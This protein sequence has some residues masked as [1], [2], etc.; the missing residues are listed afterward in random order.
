[1][2]RR[3][4]RRTRKS[5][6]ETKREKKTEKAQEKNKANKKILFSKKL[7][8]PLLILILVLILVLSM[9]PVGEFSAQNKV[10]L[11]SAQLVKSAPLKEIKESK[12]FTKDSIRITDST[13]DRQLKNFMSTK[14]GIASQDTKL[15]K[16]I[17]SASSKKFVY[18]SQYYNGI[19]VYG[20]LNTFYIAN[21]K[22]FFTK[23][24][25]HNIENLDTAPSVSIESAKSKTKQQLQT[26]G[27]ER[28]RD[29][30]SEQMIAPSVQNK[31]KYYDIAG[32][33]R[34]YKIFKNMNELNSIQPKSVQLI[35]YPFK[36][37]Y[38]LAY[39]IVYPVLYQ[40]PAQ[41]IYFVNAHTGEIIDSKDGLV[42]YDLGG[43][44]AVKEWEDPFTDHIQLDQPAQYNK[45]TINNNGI[46]I[47]GN[48]QFTGYYQ[49]TGLNGSGT[50]YSYLEGPYVRVENM[51]MDSA[52]HSADISDGQTQHSWSWSDYDN[53]YLQEEENVF[54]HVNVERAYADYIG[55]TEMNFQVPARVGINDYCNAYWTPTDMSINFFQAGAGCESTGV[56][57]DV[58]YHEYGHGIFYQLNPTAAADYWDQSGNM[59]EGVA[60]YFACTINDNPGQGEGFFIND[61]EP[62]RICNSDDRYPEDY[63]PEPHSGAQI[64]SGALWD[65][66]EQTGKQVLD[67]LLVNALRLQPYTFSELADS[68]VIADDDNSN[69]GDGTPHMQ[70]IC[71][72][73]LAHGIISFFCAGNSSE[74]FAYIHNPSR[75]EEINGIVPI[76][77]T[78]APSINHTIKN[79]ILSAVIYYTEQ[80]LV[81]GNYSVQN[82]TVY[83]FDTTRFYDWPIIFVLNVSDTSGASKIYIVEP[84]IN[85]IQIFEPHERLYSDNE[86]IP[87]RGK[88]YVGEN[89]QEYGL[90]S[91]CSNETESYYPIVNNFNLQP[92]NGL[93]EG[94]LGEINLNSVNFNGNSICNLR[95]ISRYI[96]FW[97]DEYK[98]FSVDP[99]IHEGWPV[100]INWT[101]NYF[102]RP[103]ISAGLLNPVIFSPH[104]DGEHRLFVFARQPGPEL[105]VFSHDGTRDYQFPRTVE[106][107][108][109]MF[110]SDMAPAI[111]TENGKDNVVLYGSPITDD[112]WW[113]IYPFNVF[114]YIASDTDTDAAPV[115]TNYTGDLVTLHRSVVVA[116]LN[117]DSRKEFIIRSHLNTVL[118]DESGS[119]VPGWPKQAISI[120][121]G[122]Y[123]YAATPATGNFDNDSNDEIVIF[124]DYRIEN[125]QEIWDLIM[126]VFNEDGSEIEGFPRSLYN[127]PGFVISSPVTADFNGDGY[128][129]V[130]FGVS[131]TLENAG[132]YI[133]DRFGNNIPGWPQ[134][135]SGNS[136]LV[137][138]AP[139]VGIENENIFIVASTIHFPGITH[140][141]D[142]NDQIMPGWPQE[143]VSRDSFAPLIADLDNDG[144]QDIL[145]T[146]RT[147]FV[148]ENTMYAWN[149]QGETIN[150]FPKKVNH[151][152][153]PATIGDIDDDGKLELA[154][155]SVINNDDGNEEEPWFALV[156]V[157]DLD[158]PASA[159]ADWPTFHGNNQRTGHFN[160]LSEPQDQGSD[161]CPKGNCYEQQGECCSVCNEND[162]ECLN[163]CNAGC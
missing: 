88:I 21:N 70:K 118:V 96:D 140:T 149:V 107:E 57:S 69:L 162:Y 163:S 138:S 146:T 59:N 83:L 37:N 125:G 75:Y 141:L 43:S 98:I 101:Y 9:Q 35:V 39:K 137:E 155:G 82:T 29:Y 161:D 60:D 142:V 25:F 117:H 104:G 51:Q 11:Q 30:V 136:R 19:P 80:Q 81:T 76:T 67:P 72:D 20:A 121:A 15:T 38:Y 7:W 46:N 63:N 110:M 31:N 153:G 128:D 111:Y 143:T 32:K 49:F 16:S 48:T 132:L 52:M 114:A 3:L 86:I 135:F 26:F 78:A 68:M 127:G 158:T 53:S 100:R 14:Y 33:E 106:A 12:V 119:I 133:V 22:L 99:T 94:V 124:E 23:M 147:N 54:Y 18:Y 103:V 160:I 134:R 97:I 120:Y 71:D 27:L 85:N 129:E 77:I 157:W 36:D 154:V 55:A 79:W 105:F 159:R 41:P 5:S 17:G 130:L 102:G 44:V 65:I 145:V 126:H 6:K 156:Y 122:E 95:F 50:L 8:A 61:P 4:I 139:A 90:E 150:G 108:N 112:L 24:N 13:A 148:G 58:I 84:E 144:K 10:S 64:V 34:E 93:L 123:G 113:F 45:I 28:V 62:L 109:M 2:T 92:Q 91:I 40:V 131:V 74:P 73:F 42:F 116:D 115:F 1:M 152:W 89:F 66:R 56:I 47:A 151:P 87:V